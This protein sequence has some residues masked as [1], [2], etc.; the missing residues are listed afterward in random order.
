MG[1]ALAELAARQHGVI[2]V[3]QLRALGLDR[4]AVDRRL[5]SGHLHRLHHGVYAVGHRSLTK[6]GRYLAAV[7]A[8]GPRAVLSHRSA[9]D[10]LGIRRTASPRIAVTVPRSGVGVP[11]VEVHRSSILTP[12]VV[13]ECD[14]IPVTSVARTLLDLAAVLFPR[15]LAQAVD[16]AERLQLFDL[17]AVEEALSRARG[18]RGARALR[19]AIAAWRP[20]DIR[21]ELEQRFAELTDRAPFERPQFNVLVEGE[22]GR[23]VVD[24]LWP[25]QRLVVQL[26]GFAYHRTRRDRERDAQID[27]DLELAGYMV[28]R[29][30]WDDVTVRQALTLRRLDRLLSSAAT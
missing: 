28:R 22:R 4:S 26:D 24:A 5:V 16:Q 18:R 15:Q 12:A 19:E 13:T 7:L 1:Q 30:T 25:A 17:G 20:R 14:G 29:L 23:H 6:H 21:S 27:G 9:A 8:C 11:G 10:L 3:R 2:S